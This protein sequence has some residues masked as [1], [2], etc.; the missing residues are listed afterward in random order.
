MHLFRKQQK[1]NARRR[2]VEN[3]EFSVNDIS[4]GQVALL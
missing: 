3:C 2:P 1:E 4:I